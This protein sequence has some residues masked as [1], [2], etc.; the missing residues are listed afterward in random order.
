MYFVV[1]GFFC[2]GLFCFG[3][4]L[5]LSIVG[6][7]AHHRHLKC[8]TGSIFYVKPQ[9]ETQIFGLYEATQKRQG[10]KRRFIP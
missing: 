9:I 10:L 3:A 2:P 1:G 6:I 7:P 8:K 4:R 5:A